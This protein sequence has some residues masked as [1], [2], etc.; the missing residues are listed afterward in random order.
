MR[1][2]ILLFSRKSDTIN[3]KGGDTVRHNVLSVR[4]IFSILGVTLAGISVGFLKL[5]AFGV[6]PFQALMSGLNAVIPISFGTLYVI[7]G[8]VLLVFSLIVDKHYVGLASIITLSLQGYVIDFSTNVLFSLFPAAGFLLRAVSFLIGI[9][10]L[11]FSTAIYFT[12]DLGV[13]AYDAIALIIT[14]TWK[15]GK[16]KFNR[17]MTDC[18]CVI[19]G[20][21]GYIA[22]GNPLYGLT[23]IVGIGT[24]VTAFCMGPLVDFFQT[25]VVTLIYYRIASE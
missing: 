21:A 8:V 25:K 7:V 5:A 10:M 6:D 3:G 2:V 17:I 23:A 16:F 12:A 1:K 13:S 14:N 11:C 24:I 4:I 18:V 15:K 9:I 22:A 19:L 20:S